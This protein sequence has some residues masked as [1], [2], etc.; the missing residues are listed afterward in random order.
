MTERAADRSAQMA[1][2]RSR[3]TK[4]EM[5]VRKWLH[6]AGLRYRLWEKRLPGKP[7]LVFPA[8]QLAVFVHGCFWHGHADCKKARIPKTKRDYWIPKLKHNAVRD[9]RNVEELCRLGWRVL[10]IWECETVSEKHL[11]SLAARIRRT[12][13]KKF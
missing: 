11:A 8:R 3:N 12:R 2:I 7:D 6:A 5:R 9:R 4:P 13:I 10:V 1:L